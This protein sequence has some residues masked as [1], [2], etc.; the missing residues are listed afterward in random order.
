MF[1]QRQGSNRTFVNT[2]TLYLQK[3]RAGLIIVLNSSDIHI[4]QYNNIVINASNVYDAET[5][6]KS[7][8]TYTWTCPNANQG[9]SNLKTSILTVSYSE[10]VKNGINFVGQ[11]LNYYVR[12]TDSQN[13]TS[14]TYLVKVT[15]T[16]RDDYSDCISVIAGGSDNATEYKLNNNTIFLEYY[17]KSNINI[18]MSV[19]MNCDNIKLNDPI[20]SNQNT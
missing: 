20:W 11:L 13:T 3:A 5:Q 12:I 2:Q 19:K 1:T 15:I 7:T 17:Q 18:L 16:Q 9:C 10:R 14:D 6:N 8:Y 4:D